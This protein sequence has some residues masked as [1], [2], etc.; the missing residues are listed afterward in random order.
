MPITPRVFGLAFQRQYADLDTLPA[1]TQTSLMKILDGD[2]LL[3]GE[4]GAQLAIAILLLL[5]ERR[6]LR[7]ILARR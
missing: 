5:K 2:A 4:D 7:R 1:E 3:P 6:N